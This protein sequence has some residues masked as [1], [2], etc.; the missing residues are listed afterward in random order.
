MNLCRDGHLQASWEAAFRE[1]V[2][3]AQT[4]CD[5]P[6]DAGNANS[7]EPIRAKVTARVDLCDPAARTVLRNG[8]RCVVPV[9]APTIPTHAACTNSL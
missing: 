5:R 4:A 7:G 2:A 3:I 1:I 9:P 8:L 6:N